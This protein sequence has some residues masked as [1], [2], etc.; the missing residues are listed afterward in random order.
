MNIPL[1]SFETLFFDCSSIQSFVKISLNNVRMPMK[2]PL[3]Y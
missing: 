1:Y 3:C 2:K